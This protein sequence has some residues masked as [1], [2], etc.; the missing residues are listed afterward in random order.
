MWMVLESIYEYV[1]RFQGTCKFHVEKLS[2]LRTD[3]WIFQGICLW[4]SWRSARLWEDFGRFTESNVLSLLL[5]LYYKSW[6]KMW[7]YLWISEDHQCYQ[8]TCLWQFFLLFVLEDHWTHIWESLDFGRSNGCGHF[9]GSMWWL[10]RQRLWSLLFSDSILVLFF[11]WP[12]GLG[13]QLTH[14]H[15]YFHGSL[16]DHFSILSSLSCRVH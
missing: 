10:K 13:W 8:I 7:Q 1:W 16:E 14:F 3:L 15:V 9:Y 5:V 11:T 6:M 12:S 2:I 4:I